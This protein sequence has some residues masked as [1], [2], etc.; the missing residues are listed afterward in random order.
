MTN[1]LCW[2]VYVDEYND[3]PCIIANHGINGDYGKYDMYGT[4]DVYFNYDSNG[5]VNILDMVF[6]EYE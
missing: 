5:E 2:D 3:Q 6:T 4:V 1:L